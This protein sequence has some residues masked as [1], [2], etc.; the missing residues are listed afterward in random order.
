MLLLRSILFDFLM[1]ATLLIMGIVLSPMAMW[2]RDGAY[3]V[4]KL[5]CRVI[6][7]YLKVLC[8]LRVEFRGTPPT[9]EAIVCSKHMSF[10]DVLMVHISLP[11]AKFIM[12]SQLRWAPVLGL[13]ALRIGAAP[14]NRSK[15]GGAVKQM[16]ENVES[17]QEKQSGQLTIFP[18][19][20]R[21]L[22]GKTMRYKIGAGVLYERFGQ[23]CYPVATNTGVFWARRSPYRKPG[24][25]ILEFLEPIPAGLPIKEFLV[26]LED[27]IETNSNRL[28]AEAGFEFPDSGSE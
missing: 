16:V 23:D 17:G 6:F 5:Y 4:M 10:L 13:Y 25:A 21:V 7:W 15:R 3:W 22:P 28:M 19:G 1:Y 20:T 2:S 14:V 8:N 11:R 18:Q 27:V 9:G 12:K 24:V 26:K